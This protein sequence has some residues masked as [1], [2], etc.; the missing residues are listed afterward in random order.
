M[1]IDLLDIVQEYCDMEEKNRKFTYF[2]RKKR[3]CF[4]FVWKKTEINIFNKLKINI[5][6]QNFW[7]DIFHKKT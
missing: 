2:V 7:A 1:E 6:G 4:L 5:V 3:F